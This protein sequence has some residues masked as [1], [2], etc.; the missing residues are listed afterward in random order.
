[1]KRYFFL[2]SVLVTLTLIVAA[3]RPLEVP[4]TPTVA[5]PSETPEPTAT[6]TPTPEPT[7]TV[8]P[9]ETLMPEVWEI[10]FRGV[11]CGERVDCG[12]GPGIKNH[13]YSIK[14]D[15][16]SLAELNIS[17]SSTIP[18]LPANAPPLRQQFPFPPQYSPDGTQIVYLGEDRKLYVVNAQTGEAIALFQASTVVEDFSWIPIA[19]WSSDGSYL[20]FLEGH[21]KDNDF[22][23][24][25]IFVVNRDGTNLRE[26]FVLHGF[27]RMGSGMCSPNGGEIALSD[28]TDIHSRPGLYI[29]NLT[30]GEP[31]MILENYHIADL[32]SPL[33]QTQP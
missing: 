24:P 3:C 33:Q 20:V 32:I 13:F 12:P 16:K 29:I 21:R 7:A 4:E 17:P 8:A 2:V 26:L 31:V 18:Q 25:T 15:G 1:M 22:L 23:A 5:L 11:F 10:W 30:T 9:T 19:C 27:E 28:A 14:S 6:E